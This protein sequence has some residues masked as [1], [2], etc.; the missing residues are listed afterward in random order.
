MFLIVG[1]A[2]LNTQRGDSTLT[3]VCSSKEGLENHFNY[4]DLPQ[5]VFV[6]AVW[7]Y[8]HSLLQASTLQ[9]QGSRDG[10]RVWFLDFGK[11]VLSQNSLSFKR[12][13][14]LM[15]LVSR[16]RLDTVSS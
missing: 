11:D 7:D 5:K 12:G 10:K 4:F 16:R 15:S 3:S 14:F 6:T 8:Y 9:N 1:P 13:E 2:I